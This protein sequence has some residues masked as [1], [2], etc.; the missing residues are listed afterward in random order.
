MIILIIYIVVVLLLAAIACFA[1]GASD[2]DEPLP[3]MLSLALFWGPLLVLVTV[4]DP[5][6]GLYWLGGFT[7][8]QVAKRRTPPTPDRTAK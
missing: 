5:F 6:F 7:A 1:C 2:D 8:R 4:C 3:A